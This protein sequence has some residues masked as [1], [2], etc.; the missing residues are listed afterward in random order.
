MSRLRRLA[1][2]ESG[3]LGIA[4]SP[5]AGEQ[6]ARNDQLRR[7]HAP[8]GRFAVA[9]DRLLAPGRRI[10]IGGAKMAELQQGGTVAA[11]GRGAEQPFRFARIGR[12]TVAAQVKAGE[13]RF[14]LAVAGCRRPRQPFRRLGIILRHAL[15][16][17]TQMRKANLRRHHPLF[18]RAAKPVGRLYRV[19]LDPGTVQIECADIELGRRMALFGRFLEPARGDVG[20]F[21]PR[22]A[23]RVYQA[24]RKLPFFEIS[25][26]TGQ[27]IEGLKFAM[28]ERVLA[29]A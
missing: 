8:L 28:A 4:L 27:G 6:I 5:G 2:P 17:E 14:G 15:P 12:D 23:A 10:A 18:R 24:D 11:V 16:G 26:A 20:P 21:L 19:A 22:V 13:Q 25:S 1:E 7:Q 9:A 3:F 29:V